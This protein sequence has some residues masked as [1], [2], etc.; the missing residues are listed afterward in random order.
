MIDSRGL[1]T[2]YSSNRRKLARKSI[3]TRVGNI[4]I[5]TGGEN[6]LV[7]ADAA[8]VAYSILALSERVKPME[9]YLCSRNSEPYLTSF[10]S[11]HDSDDDEQLEDSIKKVHPI[12]FQIVRA[13]RLDGG[14]SS[15]RLHTPQPRGNDHA[16]GPETPVVSRGVATFSQHQPEHLI[17]RAF[18]EDRGFH[19]FSTFEKILS[20]VD[21]RLPLD[22]C[23]AFPMPDVEGVEHR[24]AVTECGA[25]ID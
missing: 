10:P 12:W 23:G 24:E 14:Q 22:H 20:T 1:T 7:T 13:K 25:K 2:L 9:A 11:G 19:A 6:I 3:G 21:R 15:L 16:L 18:F 8:D 5:C 4:N 17:L